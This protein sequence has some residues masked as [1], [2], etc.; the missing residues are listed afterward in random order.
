MCEIAPQLAQLFLSGHRPEQLVLGPLALCN[1][2]D[3]A[4]HMLLAVDLDN[5][6]RNQYRVD[7]VRATA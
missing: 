1:I 6:S 4:E 7:C 2:G 5:S 3:E